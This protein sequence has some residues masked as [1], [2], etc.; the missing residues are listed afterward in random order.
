MIF[1]SILESAARILRK[2]RQAV[3]AARPFGAW[4]ER[5]ACGPRVIFL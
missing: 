5:I 4:S 2:L 3:A 1:I